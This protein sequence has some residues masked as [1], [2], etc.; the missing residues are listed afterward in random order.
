MILRASG[1]QYPQSWEDLQNNKG[2]ELTKTTDRV[3]IYLEFQYLDLFGHAQH[4]GYVW[5]KVD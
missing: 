1:H 3:K 2:W 4:P 5:D